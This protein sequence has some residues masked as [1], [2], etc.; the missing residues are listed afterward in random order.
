[1]GAIQNSIQGLVATA[2]VGAAAIGKAVEKNKK[3]NVGPD[4]D[5]LAKEKA[6]TTARRKIMAKAEQNKITVENLQK[7]KT[8]KA[9]REAEANIIKLGGDQ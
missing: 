9:K 8:E 7:L 6:L 5:K 2:G 4:K 3:A 1:M